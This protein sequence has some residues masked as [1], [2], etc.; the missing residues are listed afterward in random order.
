MVFPQEGQGMPRGLADLYLPKEN[1]G[2]AMVARSL[3]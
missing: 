3:S 2:Q 1:F